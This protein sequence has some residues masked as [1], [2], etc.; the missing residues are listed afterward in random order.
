MNK[1]VIKLILISST[2]CQR[3]FKKAFTRMRKRLVQPRQA[4]V[5]KKKRCS[6][7]FFLFGL[8]DPAGLG[9]AAGRG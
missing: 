2:V 7:L 4:N 3:A 9:A 5:P 8:F 1:D 6:F